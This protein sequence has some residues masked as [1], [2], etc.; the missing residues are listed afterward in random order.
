MTITI[1]YILTAVNCIT[2]VILFC[3]LLELNRI[4]GK[5]VENIYKTIDD[6]LKLIERK[7]KR[8]E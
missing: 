8:N 5:A 2:I 3:L 1:L 6:I 7:S 4:N